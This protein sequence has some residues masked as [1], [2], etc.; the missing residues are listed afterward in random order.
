MMLLRSAAWGARGG[1]R[2]R[3]RRRGPRCPPEHARKVAEMC[4]A[5]V[6][7]ALALPRPSTAMRRLTP[8]DRS[9]ETRGGALR[10]SLCSPRGQAQRGAGVSAGRDAG[11]LPWPAASDAATPPARAPR[12]TRR[13][14]AGRGRRSAG[15]IPCRRAPVIRGAHGSETR[16]EPRR[17]ARQQPDRD[18]VGELDAS[19]ASA[20][21]PAAKNH[22]DRPARGAPSVTYEVA[23]RRPCLAGDLEVLRC[24]RHLARA[25]AELR[26]TTR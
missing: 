18:L 19:R 3:P 22:L 12:T 7:V 17:S 11:A 8:D 10:G 5:V 20:A 14:W 6:I 26:P 1:R 24:G 21:A 2:P 9:D 23:P 13:R 4:C 15:R 16:P 25:Q